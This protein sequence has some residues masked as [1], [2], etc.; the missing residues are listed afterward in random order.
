[1]ALEPGIHPL[2][3]T[4]F[5]GGASDSRI[6]ERPITRSVAGIGVHRRDTRS[7]VREHR[8]HLW[9]V[10][11]LRHIAGRV[12]EVG[13]AS[14]LNST[15]DG[16][17]LAANFLLV[18]RELSPALFQNADDASDEKRASQRRTQRELRE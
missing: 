16:F 13:A 17:H 18:V 1:M 2:S 11:W 4:Q 10:S 9:K 12:V 15:N 6:L 8:V 7:Q 3:Q 14:R 5:I